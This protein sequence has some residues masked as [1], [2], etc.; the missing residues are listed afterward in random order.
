MA[1][2]IPQFVSRLWSRLKTSSWFGENFNLLTEV[3]P[4]FSSSATMR[5][6][7]SLSRMTQY[8]MGFC[9]IDLNPCSEI[10]STRRTGKDFAQTYGSQMMNRYDLD[11]PLN[12]SKAPP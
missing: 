2:F 3:I 6:T 1:I 4:C 9:V 7:L 5:L 11:D 10:T 8:W 12:F